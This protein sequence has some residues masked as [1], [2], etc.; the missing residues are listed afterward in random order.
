[1]ILMRRIGFV[2]IAM[3]LLLASLAWFLP[4]MLPL[5][6]RL[7]GV[8]DVHFSSIDVGLRRTRIEGLAIGEPPTQRVTV[9]EAEYSLGGIVKGRFDHLRIDG[10]DAQ[11]IYRDGAFSLAGED[12]TEQGLNEP[13]PGGESGAAFP[14]LTE[15]L[16]IENS[17]L[18]IQTDHG[19]LRLPFAGEVV[20]RDE[21]VRFDLDIPRAVFDSANWGS[22]EATSQL[23]GHLVAEGSIQPEQITASGRLEMS[24]ARLAL[25]EIAEPMAARAS[26]EFQF[27]DG[28]LILTGPIEADGAN[29]RVTGEIGAD[30]T[31]DRHWHLGSIQAADIAVDVTALRQHAVNVT[32]AQ[33]E[34]SASG[35]L[36]DLAGQIDVEVEGLT[37][38]LGDVEIQ[39]AKGQRTFDFTVRQRQLDVAARLPGK[40]FSIDGISVADRG[41]VALATGWFTVVWP[42]HQDPWLRYSLDDGLIDVDLALVVDPTRID[43]GKHRFWGRI[44]DLHV[45][46]SGDRDGSFEGTMRLR[47]GRT[48][49]PSNNLALIGIESDI[50]FSDQGMALGD[51]IPLTIRALRPLG[52]PRLFK[53]LRLDLRL[54][55]TADQ[56]DVGGTLKLAN[57]ATTSLDISATYARSTSQAKIML[58]LPPLAFSDGQLQPSDISPLLDGVLSDV[59]GEIALEGEIV[60]M[61]DT[62]ESDL[63]LLISELGFAIGPARLSRINSVIRF[64]RLNPLSTPP[65]QLLSVGL[66]DVGLPLTNGLVSMQLRPDGQLA[67]DQLTWQ[68]ADGTIRAAPFTFG[69]DVK[70]LT[71]VLQAEQLDLEALLRLTPLDEVKGE[72]RIDGTLPLTI[73][74]TA[75]IEGGELAASGPGVIRYVPSSVPGVLQAGGES[76]TLMLQALENFQYD[77]LNLTLNGKTDGETNIGLH[78]KGANPQLYDGYPVEFNLNLDG[79]L[80]NLIQTNLENYQ[81]PDRIR[82]RLQGFER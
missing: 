13:F 75:A 37:A 34:L 42:E 80:A 57:H 73:G 69:S 38:R 71:M 15:T 72:G 45:T 50:A 43:V 21:G 60:W 7:A 1:M 20:R 8:G 4:V 5:G 44:E 63:S 30:V 12:P 78:L 25:G 6:L 26:I 31:V 19:A 36:D 46:L 2:V 52:E 11:L 53:P 79:N 17:K 74:G 24:S 22:I 48:D 59:V 18:D 66:L 29:A 65:A 55:P 62:L 9:V 51:P 16:L 54:R 70:D 81:I 27:E 56:W 67:V 76:V 23:A 40:K 10:L 68:L 58:R 82:E 49:L 33:L 35:V 41:E 39:G 28:E 64:D 47:K 61:G 3:A 32:Q 77:A 14:I